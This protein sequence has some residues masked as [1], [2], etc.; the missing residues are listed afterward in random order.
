MGG[1]H[2]DP[3]A[4]RCGSSR[5]QS[6]REPRRLRAR[7]VPSPG[8]CGPRRLP[9]P[10]RSPQSRSH[11]GPQQGP[12]CVLSGGRWYSPYDDVYITDA[13]A[14]DIDHLVP[15]AE[16]WD[17][18]ASAWTSAERQSYAND[19]GD[20]LALIA[21]TAKTNRS[22]SDQGPGTWQ[23]RAVGYRCEYANLL[24]RGEG[25]LWPGVR[26]RRAGRAGTGPRRV[27]ERAGRGHARPVAEMPGAAVR[28]AGWHGRPPR[29]I[30]VS[31]A[32]GASY[33]R[34][35]RG[36][37]EAHGRHPQGRHRRAAREAV[38]HRRGD[39]RGPGC[40]PSGR[41]RPC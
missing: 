14:L 30:G 7:E 41:V 2:R 18:G 36:R 23:P 24:D 39:P 10:G 26:P 35:V 31:L 12:G 6:G 1:D 3:D 13:R 29:R 28:P 27:P 34:T 20:E 4:G 38:R 8:R 33:G 9:Q 21:V 37:R 40:R 32:C 11:R 22:E 25:P 15:L 16:A 17:S 19:L 5:I